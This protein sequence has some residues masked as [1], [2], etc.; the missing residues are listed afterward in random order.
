MFKKM[1]TLVLVLAL[2]GIASAT[3]GANWM[4][5]HSFENGSYGPS[6]TLGSGNSGYSGWNIWII[7]HG[8]GASY[9]TWYS[10]AMP[11]SGSANREDNM[12]WQFAAGHAVTA[13]KTYAVTADISTHDS[14]ASPLLNGILFELVYDNGSFGDETGQVVIASTSV[15]PPTGGWGS[16]SYSYRATAAD[17]AAAAAAIG[18]STIGLRIRYDWSANGYGSYAGVDDVHF[19]PEPATVALLGLGGLALFRRRRAH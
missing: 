1:L 17:Q 4:S 16:M 8:L 10:G 11:S 5:D 12:F 14:T 15:S 19:T 18:G 2:A 7:S 13:G 3:P 6:W 9:G